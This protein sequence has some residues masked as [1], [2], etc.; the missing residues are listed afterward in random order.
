MYGSTAMRR[1]HLVILLLAA[2]CASNGVT[3]ADGQQRTTRN[4]TFFGPSDSEY[5]YP[6][7]EGKAGQR[8]PGALTEISQAVAATT[9][10]EGT[11]VEATGFEILGSGKSARQLSVSIAIEQH[12]RFRMDTGAGDTG[13]SLRFAKNSGEVRQGGGPVGILDDADFG[14]P[15]ALP[16]H[17]QEIANRPDAA[18]VN[19]GSIRAGQQRFNKVTITLFDT[20]TGIP[21]AASLY[22]DAASHLLIKSVFLAHSAGAISRQYLKVVTYSDY[23]SIQSLEFPL[24]YTESMDGQPLIAL[25]L[26]SANASSSHNESY[27]A[28]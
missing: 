17:L 4:R 19:D 28:F 3:S 7:V 10:P 16:V 6:S 21:V 2:L 15:L 11:G 25:K 26:T 14:D 24:E 1:F 22:F 8:D 23:S 9:P 5:S 13:R 20:R 18:V 12:G 27:F